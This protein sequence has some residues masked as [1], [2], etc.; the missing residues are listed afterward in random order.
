MHDGLELAERRCAKALGCEDLRDCRERCIRLADREQLVAAAQDRL[1]SLDDH[2]VRLCGPLRARV[3][4]GGF[5]WTAHAPKKA[6]IKERK[7]RA[8][9]SKRGRNAAESSQTRR[10]KLRGASV[11]KSTVGSYTPS[12]QQDDHSLI[13]ERSE[14]QGGL[15][16]QTVKTMPPERT[17]RPSRG[18]VPLQNLRTPSS[19][20]MRAKAWNVLRY[21]CLALRLCIRVLTVLRRRQLRWT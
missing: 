17:R 12:A 9:T 21:S 2:L 15:N 3:E 5:G 6:V 14:A 8:G 10:R 11:S 16:A 13:C 19:D 7:Q 18:A 1:S 20:P 4:N